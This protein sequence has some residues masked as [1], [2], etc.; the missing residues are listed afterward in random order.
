MMKFYIKLILGITLIFFFTVIFIFIHEIRS[1]DHDDFYNFSLNDTSAVTKILIWDKSPDT[2]F[3]SRQ[4][5]NTWL[6]NKDSY[7]I[8]TLVFVYE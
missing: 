7:N 8:L 2:V 5:N 1:K 4:K 3:L 6:V